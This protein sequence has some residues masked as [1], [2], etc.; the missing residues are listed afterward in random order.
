MK[1]VGNMKHYFFDEVKD[2]LIGKVGTPERDEYERK[3]NEAMNID[4]TKDLD[5]FDSFHTDWGGDGS[6][7]DIAENLRKSRV[8]NREIPEW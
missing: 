8:F 5:V 1:R 4:K 6:P 3:V 2:K 7:E